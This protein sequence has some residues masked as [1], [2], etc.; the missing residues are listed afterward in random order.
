MQS[1]FGLQHHPHGG[2]LRT[3]GCS[4]RM[5]L[6]RAPRAVLSSARRACYRRISSFSQH[7]LD[8]E[9]L[10]GYPTSLLG[11]KH[12]LGDELAVLASHLKRLI[13]SN[14]PVVNTARWVGRDTGGGA[15]CLRRT[16]L[17]YGWAGVRLCACVVGQ[18]FWTKWWPCSSCPAC[19][20]ECYS[21]RVMLQ[22]LNCT[23]PSEACSDTECARCH[24]SSFPRNPC[25]H[26]TCAPSPHTYT[27]TIQHM[28]AHTM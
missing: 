17:K 15:V 7:L 13:G 19:V 10:V 24:G 16:T 14:H 8:A 21:V 18:S 11:L 28:Q 26:T 22:S 6:G 12:M 1:S 20:S 9:R 25:V 27:H 5:Y 2:K 23:P 4:G 3:D